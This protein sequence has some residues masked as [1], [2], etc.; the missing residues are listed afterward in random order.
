MTV[1]PGN[2]R[3]A[4][5]AGLLVDLAAIGGFSAGKYVGQASKDTKSKA[6]Y[7]F[8]TETVHH[9]ESRRACPAPNEQGAGRLLFWPLFQVKRWTR[10]VNG[11][12][13]AEFTAVPDIKM[14]ENIRSIANKQTH[15]G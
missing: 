3:L 6:A 4:V 11:L 1:A 12:Q 13:H 14:K 10:M 7:G 2:W 8:P 15:R 9:T 5:P